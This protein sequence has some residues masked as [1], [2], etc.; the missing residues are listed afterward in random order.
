MSGHHIGTALAACPTRGCM[1]LLD[2]KDGTCLAC[3]HGRPIVSSGIWPEYTA[4]MKAAQEK[5]HG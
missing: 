1:G 3:N 4:A 5:R 2:P